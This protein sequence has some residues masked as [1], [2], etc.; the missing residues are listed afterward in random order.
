MVGLFE[1]L[2]NMGGST[3]KW[4]EPYP[5]VMLFNIAMEHPIFIDES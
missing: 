2:K 5:H 1:S 3:K 4:R